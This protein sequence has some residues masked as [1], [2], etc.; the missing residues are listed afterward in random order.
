MDNPSAVGAS[1]E[2]IEVPP[3]LVDSFVLESFA[4][5]PEVRLANPVQE[6]YG[7][8]FHAGCKAPN[9]GI[10]LLEAN[11]NMSRY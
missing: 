10:L 6:C 2:Y 5:R 7:Q 1:I 8:P 9:E 11:G 4:S 3:V